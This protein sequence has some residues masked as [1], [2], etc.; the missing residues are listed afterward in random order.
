M[1]QEE[2]DELAKM[3]GPVKSLTPKPLIDM[4]EKELEEF[5]SGLRDCTTQ[6]Q[7]L[8]AS[9]RVGKADKPDANAELFE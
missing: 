4:E 9:A 7:T 5:V 6:F 3:E 2:I 1:T 8:I